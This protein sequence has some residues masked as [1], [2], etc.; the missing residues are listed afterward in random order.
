MFKTYFHCTNVVVATL[1]FLS[2]CPCF[3]PYPEKQIV[4]QEGSKNVSQQN[5]EQFC[6]RNNYSWFAHNDVGFYQH[7]KHCLSG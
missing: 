7:E 3:D 6:C 2:I 5:Q 1:C 4:S